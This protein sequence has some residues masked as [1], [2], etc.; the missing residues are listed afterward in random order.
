MVTSD[1]IEVCI[2]TLQGTAFELLVSPADT[3]V[4]IKCRI[5]RLEGI[6]VSQQHLIWK[7]QE[8]PDDCSLQECNITDGATIK[9][10]L[11]MRGGPVNIRKAYLEERSTLQDVA[12]YLDTT[13]EEVSLCAPR[14]RAVRLVVMRDGERVH[15]YT[16]LDTTVK[17]P[18]GLLSEDHTAPELSD[19][20]SASE[21]R[22]HLENQITRRKVQQLQ[23]KMRNLR[24]QKEDQRTPAPERAKAIAPPPK[25]LL[26]PIEAPKPQAPVKQDR[27]AATAGN[28]RAPA[29]VPRNLLR[30]S[31]QSFHICFQAFL[32]LPD[33]PVFGKKKA[34]RALGSGMVL[35]RL[36]T[37]SGCSRTAPRHW[38]YPS[39]IPSGSHASHNLP[40]PVARANSTGAVP[41]RT[42]RN[43]G[44]LHGRA[45]A[46]FQARCRKYLL[47]AT[48]GPADSSS[49]PCA[50]LPEEGGA[51]CAAEPTRYEV[52]PPLGL[53]EQAF[54][55]RLSPDCERELGQDLAAAVASIFEP[56]DL[57][58]SDFQPRASPRL[59]RVSVV[60][61][62][63][64]TRPIV[65][66]P[67]TPDKGRACNAKAPTGAVLKVTG[68]SAPPSSVPVKPV[69]LASG[70]PSPRPAFSKP[71]RP[72]SPATLLE[73]PPAALDACRK[74]LV[75]ALKPPPPPSA[76]IAEGICQALGNAARHAAMLTPSQMRELP[77]LKCVDP[78][79]LWNL[80]QELITDQ[81]HFARLAAD[82]DGDNRKTPPPNNTVP[83]SNGPP[84]GNPERSS[85][86]SADASDS[87]VTASSVGTL[88]AESSASAGSM[89]A[90]S[91]G[92]AGSASGSNVALSVD[93]GA[94]S[95]GELSTGNGAELMPVPVD[96]D[97]NST[98]E[99]KTDD[100]PMDPLHPLGKAKKKG[101]RCSWC[102]RKTGLASTY[103]CRCG[104]TFCTVHR[105]AEAH[106][107]S[108]DY[109]AEG[110]HILQ[111]N[112]PVVKA[113]KLPKI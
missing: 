72:V 95:S 63:K 45:S 96:E 71:L 61:R 4:S 102:K 47:L 14:L 25:A 107:C 74:D 68:G 89:S 40:P 13:G 28:A 85:G 99:S 21:S 24:L 16:V 49:S 37:T 92:M 98:S 22:R 36:P 94:A 42:E 56:L 87:T 27:N 82:N 8:L 17:T 20:D 77:V 101:K 53:Q 103:V 90:D 105:Y 60:Q 43:T 83:T 111:R 70:P 46:G 7:S 109:K 12:K 54:L 58:W 80:E 41:K 81:S 62:S 73:M 50:S 31:R 59:V 10:V 79:E 104:N 55:P 100:M 86:S 112:N 51:A 26:P 76:G 33:V 23:K 93:V 78:H 65:S 15:L 84:S 108:H 30:S 2:E 18:S 113:A 1:V 29:V 11:A 67:Y 66:P 35:P 91:A 97:S 39:L 38:R 3:V 34:G 9:L 88:P 57:D 6:P 48:L 19:E 69:P 64:T 75:D 52:R 106:A 32:T 110:R 44:A 5:S